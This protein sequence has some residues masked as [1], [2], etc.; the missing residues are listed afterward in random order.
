MSFLLHQLTD[1][2]CLSGSVPVKIRT[3]LIQEYGKRFLLH[4]LV[5]ANIELVCCEPDYSNLLF[6]GANKRHVYITM[7]LQS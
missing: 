7:L 6:K 3:L 2:F 4:S 1:S 5:D